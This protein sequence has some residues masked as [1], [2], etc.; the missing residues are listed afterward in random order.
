MYAYTS[1]PHCHIQ[2]VD[3]WSHL[4]PTEAMNRVVETRRFCN[5]TET[6]SACDGLCHT[7]ESAARNMCEP[8]PWA[9]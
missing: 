4:M 7:P 1:L 2:L 5:A 6:Y 3:L 9:S 8:K